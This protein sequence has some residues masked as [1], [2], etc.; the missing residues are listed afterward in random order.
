MGRQGVFSPLRKGEG[1]QKER[2]AERDF[3][4]LELS[5]HSVVFESVTVWY[6]GGK[7]SR[8]WGNQERPIAVLPIATPVP[9]IGRREQGAPK[10]CVGVPGGASTLCP[11]EWGGEKKK[12]KL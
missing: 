8:R 9:D 2:L 1:V 6:S 4:K 12:M 5:R 10:Q 11:A 3:G 7:A